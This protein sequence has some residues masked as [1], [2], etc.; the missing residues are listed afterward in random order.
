MSIRAWVGLAVLATG[1]AFLTHARVS[2]WR[3]NQT[4]WTAEVLSHPSACRPRVNYA[5]AL[6]DADDESMIEAARVAV[7]VCGASRGQDDQSVGV[8][9][10]SLVLAR[11]QLAKG[12]QS[13]AWK[14]LKALTA[15]QP[16][17][18]GGAQLCARWGWDC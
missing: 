3:N 14:T 1:L 9:W 6:V 8:G 17:F 12:Q 16:T 7:A 2:V 5:A 15:S 4:L 18:H 13:N 11:T 10:A